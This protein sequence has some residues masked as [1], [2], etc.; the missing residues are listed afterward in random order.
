MNMNNTNDT[1]PYATQE[2]ISFELATLDIPIVYITSDG[3]IRAPGRSHSSDYMNSPKSKTMVKIHQCENGRHS[4]GIYRFSAVDF[5]E[6]GTATFDKLLAARAT[7]QPMG[8]G[9]TDSWSSL[10][11]WAAG[12]LA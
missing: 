2:T 5:V 8:Y 9:T 6:I 12:A 10:L 4:V 11:T 3:R 1:P 7:F